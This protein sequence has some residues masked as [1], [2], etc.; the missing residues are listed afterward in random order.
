[1]FTV[2][3]PERLTIHKDDAVAKLL[4]T[5]FQTRFGEHSGV[6]YP[7]TDLKVNGE[8]IK[9]KDTR[10]G[11]AWSGREFLPFVLEHPNLGTEFTVRMQSIAVDDGDVVGLTAKS[12]SLDECSFSALQRSTSQSVSANLVE[13]SPAAVGAFGRH[14]RAHFGRHVVTT[15]ADGKGGITSLVVAFFIALIVWLVLMAV[16]GLAS[17]TAE[18]LEKGGRIFFVLI[19]FGIVWGWIQSVP[20]LERLLIVG[21]VPLS[22]WLGYSTTRK[23]RGNARAI[24]EALEV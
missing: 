11:L 4:R 5:D 2:P 7:V 22:L 10:N 19:P 21:A 17:G 14:L 8:E 20:L 12:G 3:N 24:C 13:A 6:I 15:T 18:S 23:S 1:M 9:N 16:M